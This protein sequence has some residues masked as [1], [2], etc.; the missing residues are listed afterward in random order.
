MQDHKSAGADAFAAAASPEKPSV[1]SSATL[2]PFRSRMAL[3]ATV[4]PCANSSSP[5]RSTAPLA[6]ALRA[7]ISGEDGVLG[8]LATM[9]WLSFTV[10]QIRK[11]TADFDACSSSHC[12][13]IYLRPPFPG[14]GIHR[15]VEL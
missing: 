2:A 14:V 10:N 4:D 11:R 7:P 12:M 6:N 15:K 1:T 3:V 9:I 13:L 5:A 8:D